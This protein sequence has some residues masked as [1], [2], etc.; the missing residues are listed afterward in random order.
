M[1]ALFHTF[2]RENG[3][4]IYAAR[5]GLAYV[6]LNGV[7]AILLVICPALFVTIEADTLMP[8]ATFWQLFR[9]VLVARS[10]R[11]PRASRTHIAW[12]SGV[13]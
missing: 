10:A 4:R 13:L 8:Y 12:R 1:P 7:A 3:R 6:E 9:F 2:G 11:G 5:D